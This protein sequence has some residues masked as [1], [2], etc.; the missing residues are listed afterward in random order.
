MKYLDSDLEKYSGNINSFTRMTTEEVESVEDVYD[1]MTDL[2]DPFIVDFYFTGFEEYPAEIDD[3]NE[4]ITINLPNTADISSL[5][6]KFTTSD[7][8]YVVLGEEV[9]ESNVGNFDYS[10]PITFT[11]LNE[12]GYTDY[13]VKVVVSE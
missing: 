13:S 5:V 6:V 9:V 11:C 3:E 10:I 7:E 1:E 8:S 12:N 2:S 4:V